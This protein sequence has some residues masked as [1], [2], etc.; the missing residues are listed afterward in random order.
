MIPT[1]RTLSVGALTRVEGEGALHIR[2]R[3][4]ALE[5]VELNIYEPPRFFEAFLRGRSYTEPPDITAR[6]CGICPV[7]YQVSACNAI[8]AACGVT[9]DPALIQLRRLLYCGEWMHSHM[10]HIYL[11]HAPDFLGYPDAISLARDQRENVERGLRLKKAGNRLMEFLGGR[12]IHPINVRLGGF[13]SVPTRNELVGLAEQLRRALDDALAT[14]TWVS[15]FD[16]P[17]LELDHELL[18][19]RAPDGYPIEN[20]EIARSAGNPFNTAEFSDHVVESQVP[21][22]TALHAT[23]D[24]GRYLTGPLARYSLN[25]SA[26]S[27]VARQAAAEAGL[28]EQCRNPFRSIVVRAVEVVYAIDEALRIIDDYER[29]ARPFVDVPARAGVGHGVSEAPRGLLYHRYQID[30]DGLIE[31]ATIIPPTSQNQAAIE[32]D[33]VQVVSEN[34]SLDDGELTALCERV[35]RNHD[36]CISCS[37][38]FLRLTV[39]RC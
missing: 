1:T 5:S 38:H 24:G 34:L 29:P 3:D 6:V 33:L 4:G 16:F 19:L 11:L 10:L 35:I 26:L 30:G 37:A 23:L 28:A 21:H 22:S 39:D 8:E 7:A 27:P 17:E 25:S 2:L 20:G 15:G 36:P 14:V 18:A 13:Y 32:A 12:A 9:L 31:A